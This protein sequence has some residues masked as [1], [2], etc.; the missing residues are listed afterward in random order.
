MHRAVVRRLTKERP[1]AINTERTSHHYKWVDDACIRDG[2]C[3]SLPKYSRAQHKGRRAIDV[4]LL[5][6]PTKRAR[7]TAA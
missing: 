5:G 7:V 3:K 1:L 4:H 2:W 6:S